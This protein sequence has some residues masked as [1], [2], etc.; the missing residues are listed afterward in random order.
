M[1]YSFN[2]VEQPWIPC[3]APDGQAR[4]LSL[5]ET[6]KQAHTLRGIA[7][8]SP[9][10]TAAIYRLLLAVLH[11]A[12]RGPESAAAWNELWQAGKWDTPWLNAYLDKWQHRFDLF[13][14]Q[15]PFYQANDERVRSKSIISLA[16]D[17]ASG[18]NAALFDHHTEDVGAD[19]LPAKAARIL[20]VAQTFGLAGLTGIEQK[21]TDA[22]WGRGI[23]FMVEGD[24]LFQTLAL[25]CL[26]YGGDYPVDVPIIGEDL[27]A[28]ESDDP[29]K[30]RE[31]PNGYLDY[32]TWQARR[33]LLKP[34]GNVSQARVSQ[35]TIAPAL[36]LEASRLDPFKNYRKDEK[37]GYLSSRFYEDRV[38]WRDSSAL[39]NVKVSDNHH[40]P[41][42]FAWVAL[43]ADKGYIE[44]HRTLRYIALGMANDQAKVEFFRQEHMPLPLAFLENSDLVGKLEAALLL[45]TETRKSIWSAASWMSV[46]IVAPNADGK[47]WKDINQNTK[48][49]GAHLYNHWSVE[50]DFWG[51]LEVP[52]FHLLE[53]LPDDPEIAMKT[54]KDTL[55]HTAWEALDKAA[56]QAGNTIHALKAAVRARGKLGYGL[57]ELFPEPEKEVIA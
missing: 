57:K 49:Q 19:V 20:I 2:L 1:T 43:L 38:L 14:P 42:N 47:N 40:P 51:T 6:L 24:T 5:R 28:W 32:L 50:R 45:A 54:W 15:R 25:N 46:L 9:L 36:R 52:F 41:A 31:V 17:M 7:G 56:N 29:Y 3:S 23:I 10:E 11:S 4:E 21:F 16:I 12:L 48:V 13:D 27:P 22:P 35:V 8:D 53:G 55:K 44:T 39:F 33:I 34:E 18:N 26:R 37:S 30:P